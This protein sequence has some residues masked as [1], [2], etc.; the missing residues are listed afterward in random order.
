MTKK[1]TPEQKAA[2]KAARDKAK[3]SHKRKLGLSR[4]AFLAAYDTDTQTR[5]AVRKALAEMSEDCVVKDAEFRARCG[6][7]ASGWRHVADEPEFRKYQFK[8]SQELFWALPETIRW[9]K[10][11]NP[12]V[13]EL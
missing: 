12:R 5:L 1:M 6:S 2:K 7:H 10:S 11:K 3:P 13:R 4:D 9:A 8:L